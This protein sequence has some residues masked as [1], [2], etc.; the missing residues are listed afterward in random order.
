[1]SDML[2]LAMVG[3]GLKATEYATSWL[4]MPDVSVVA[5]ADV[6]RAARERFSDL[7]ARAG[8]PRP[9]PFANIDALVAQCATD[10]DAVYL[11][12]P[13]A[14][15][16]EGAVTV[17]DA[18]IDLLLEKPMVTSV[19]EAE[20]LIDARRKS[21][22]TVVVAFQGGLSPLI[23]DTRVRAASGEFGELVSVSASIW[24][25]WA[26]RY[27]GQWKQKPQVSGGG[28]MFDTGAHMMNTVCL[29]AASGFA[30]VSAYMGNRGRDVDIVSAVAARLANGTLVTLNAAGDGPAQCA[31]HIALFFTEAIIHIDAWGQWREISGPTAPCHRE[32]VE[33]TNNPLRAFIDIR[34]GRMPNPSSVEDGLRFARL[35]DAIKA[36]A[37]RDGEPV[38]IARTADR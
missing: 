22:A 3:T 33:I 12:T 34:A 16:A 28:F 20:T 14:F 21:G 30:R 27:A 2:R 24:E 37:S 32:E 13:H 6:D 38:T 11:S 29:L 15:H 4:A 1:M 19:G 35:W 31:S 26:D 8:R 25:D 23:R 7:C 9:E 18:G 10:I 5:I 17:V 36:S